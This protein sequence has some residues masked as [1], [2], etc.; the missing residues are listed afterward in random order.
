MNRCGIW[1]RDR[2]SDSCC[3]LWHCWFQLQKSWSWVLPW[4]VTV[5]RSWVWHRHHCWGLWLSYLM[6]CTP[7]S[8]AWSEPVLPQMIWPLLGSCCLLFWLNPSLQIHSMWI[9][10]YLEKRNLHVYA[11]IKKKKAVLSSSSPRSSGK[12]EEDSWRGLGVVN[13]S[14][15]RFVSSGKE[16]WPRV[17]I[18]MRWAN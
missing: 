5:R 1:G 14:G 11:Y 8:L 9:Y 16:R 4:L 2:S 12:K 3:I 18:S 17:L 15:S 6:D 7:L 10:L 13:R